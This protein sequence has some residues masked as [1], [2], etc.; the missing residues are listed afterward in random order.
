MSETF[1]RIQVHL[2]HNPDYNS[3]MLLERQAS[4][5]QTLVHDTTL[6]CPHLHSRENVLI[7]RV[8]VVKDFLNDSNLFLWMLV[9]LL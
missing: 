1:K 7:K 6:R 9:L 4:L 3:V 2:N 5:I 8:V